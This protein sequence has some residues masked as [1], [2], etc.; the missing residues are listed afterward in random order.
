MRGAFLELARNHGV[1]GKMISQPFF[2]ASVMISRAVEWNSGSASDLPTIDAHRLQ[3]SIRHP[4][5]DDELVDLATRFVRTGNFR[6]NLCTTDDRRRR[7]LR[8][9]ERRSKRVDLFHQ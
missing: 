8:L 1:V 9:F 2:F 3:E 6:R 7:S 5:A 4:S